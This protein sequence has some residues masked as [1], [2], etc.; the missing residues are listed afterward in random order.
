MAIAKLATYG[1]GVDNDDEVDKWHEFLA[2]LGR[3]ECSRQVAKAEGVLDSTSIWILYHSGSRP[4]IHT[5]D[6]GTMCS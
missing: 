3:A 5:G 2:Y 1:V 4:S 6:V